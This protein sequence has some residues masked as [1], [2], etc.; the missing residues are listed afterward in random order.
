MFNN[1]ITTLKVWCQKVLPLVYDDSLSYYELLCK[2]VA[3]VNEVVESMNDLNKNSIQLINEIM[4]GWLDSGVIEELINENILNDIKAKIK[5]NTDAITAINE[6]TIPGVEQK[7]TDLRGTVDSN[8]TDLD[9]KITTLSSTETNNY[10][11]LLEL[12]NANEAEIN[13]IKEFNSTISSDIEELKNNISSLTLDLKYSPTD[14]YNVKKYG[15]KGD[16]I[17]DDYNAIIETI[18]KAM[19]G[20]GVVYFPAGIYNISKTINITGL[21]GLSFIGDNQ[22]VSVIQSTNDNLPIIKT[23]INST[24]YYNVFKNITFTSSVG[25]VME[26]DSLQFKGAMKRLLIEDC[27]VKNWYNGIRISGYEVC[28]F[29]RVSVVMPAQYPT[30]SGTGIIIGEYG[31]SAQG[32]NLIIS[33]CFLR[34][35][36][37]DEGVG[38]SEYATTGIAI[39]DCD[40]V[41]MY[42]TDIGAF[43]YNDMVINPNSRCNNH[44]FLQCYFDATTYGDCIKVMGTGTFAQITFNGCWIAS[45]GAIY[46]GNLS[47]KACGLN[48]ERTGPNSDIII[49]GCRF[50]NIKGI[51][52]RVVTPGF[53]ALVT[54]CFFNEVG[55]SNTVDYNHGIYLD[56]VINN[57]SLNVDNCVFSAIRGDCFFSTVNSSF[58]TVTNCKSINGTYT[59]NGNPLK[60]SGNISTLKTI[61]SANTIKVPINDDLCLVSGNTNIFNIAP[62]YNGKTICLLF[63][64]ALTVASG[65][66]NLRLQGNFT[67]SNLSLLFLMCYNN[68]W[69]EI[70]RS[71]YYTGSGSSI[72]QLTNSVNTLNAK[73]TGVTSITATKQIQVNFTN[74]SGTV[75]LNVPCTSVTATFASPQ[76]S[77]LTVEV[78][79][80]QN[81]TLTFKT[82]SSVTNTLIVNL[83]AVNG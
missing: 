70:A 51:G 63:T 25:K 61:A 72:M 16:G 79:D 81:G 32:A 76:L 2:V 22:T 50:F 60:V 29:N 15:A 62:A 39:H 77:P 33:D 36:R 23:E 52:L 24:T 75:T 9:G 43:L 48:I 27:S 83:I 49:T 26:T 58:Y 40:A 11:S 68:E 34:G 17:N 74:G 1:S 57:Y 69:I 46:N 21:N 59:F 18:T 53:Y 6:T 54:D 64:D 14:W 44:H 31:D 82:D 41:F 73:V 65:Q 47:A 3:K 67:T 10:N 7:I 45:A 4:Q 13:A 56:T 78:T 8:Y 5:A 30:E 66:G 12:I 35:S 55:I 28:W 38:G 80:A 37:G 20:C 42:N 19:E 71:D